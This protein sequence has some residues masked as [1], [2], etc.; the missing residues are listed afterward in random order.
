MPFIINSQNQTIEKAHTIKDRKQNLKAIIPHTIKRKNYSCQLLEGNWM[1]Q[2]KT[3]VERKKSQLTK[4]SNLKF[5]KTIN[6]SL[7]ILFKTTA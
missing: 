3:I 7:S 5:N 1:R 4:K 6:R 2:V